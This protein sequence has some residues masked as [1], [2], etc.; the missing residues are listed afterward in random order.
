VVSI[1]G[2]VIQA[3][4]GSTRLPGKVLEDLAGAPALLR[5][6]ER[7]R[8][9]KGVQKIVVATSTLPGDDAIAALVATQRDIG[10]WRGSEQDVLKRYAEAARYFDLDPIVRI[11]ADC[12]LI[13]PAILDSVIEAYRM[14]P[15]CDYADNVQPRLFPHGYDVQVVSRSVLERLDRQTTAPRD[16]EHVLIHIQEH[17]DDFRS[18]HI[19]PTGEGHPELRL[20]LDYPEDLALIRAIYERLYAAN[21]NF[22]FEDVLSL[23]AREPELFELNRNRAIYG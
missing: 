20:T 18:V 6:F 3:R 8:R 14:S 9:V 4:M 16:R 7:L 13:E 1:P 12:P 22:G 10:L 5:L 23:R 19:T 2:I 11:T 17:P 21:P 15:R